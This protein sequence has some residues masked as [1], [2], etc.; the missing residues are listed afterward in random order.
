MYL[1]NF[2]RVIGLVKRYS[3]F[4]KRY[5]TRREGDGPEVFKYGRSPSNI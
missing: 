2:V 3:L 4:V 1:R 5:R